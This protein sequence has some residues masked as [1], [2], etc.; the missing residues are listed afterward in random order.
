MDLPFGTIVGGREEF[1]EA[2]ACRSALTSI[3][4]CRDD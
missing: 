2:L 3:V 1:K 4:Q